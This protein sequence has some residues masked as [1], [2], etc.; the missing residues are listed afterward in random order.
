MKNI[1]NFMNFPLN[2]FYEGLVT[3]N[4]IKSHINNVAN[5][6]DF[7]TALLSVTG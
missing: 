7:F 2:C 3:G 1:L 6:S 5:T 4:A